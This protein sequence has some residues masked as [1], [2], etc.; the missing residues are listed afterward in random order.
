[1]ESKSISKPLQFRSPKYLGVAYAAILTS[2][3][4]IASITFILPSIASSEDDERVLEVFGSGLLGRVSRTASTEELV[5]TCGD[6]DP[7]TNVITFVRGGE[8]AFTGIIAGTTAQ[9]DNRG[10]LNTCKEGRVH[11]TFVTTYFFEEATVEGRTGGL[12][13]RQTGIFDRDHGVGFTDAIFT[14]LCGTG[15]LEGIHGEGTTTAP[16]SAYRLHIHFDHDHET[17][18]EFLCN[19]LGNNGDDD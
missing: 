8:N 7:D 6:T 19:G 12:V 2:I 9:V 4:L 1:M 13:M 16:P 18:W 17:G 14:T 11:L 15:E 10:L 3:L 5:H